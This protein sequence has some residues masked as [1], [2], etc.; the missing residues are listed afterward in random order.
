MRSPPLGMIARFQGASVCRPT[1]IC[2]GLVD[3]TGVVQGCWTAARKR[4]G[5]PLLFLLHQFLQ[6]AQRAV[7]RAVDLARKA[8]SPR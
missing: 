4:R 3:V 8:A 7:V 5:R 1:M 6:P 2:I